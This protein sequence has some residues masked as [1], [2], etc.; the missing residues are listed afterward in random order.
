MNGLPAQKDLSP[1]LTTALHGEMV[2]KF[3]ATLD[4]LGNPNVVPIISLDTV[5]GGKL[6]F[7]EFLIHKTRANLECDHRVA[8]CVLTEDLSVW[9][10]R[11]DFQNFAEDGPY[12]DHL[13]SKDMFRY[14]AYVGVRRAAVFDLVAVTGSRKLSKL[15]VA[16]E[17]LPVLAMRTIAR[18]RG[19][20]GLPPR[21]A[22]KFARSQALKV[23][24]FQGQDGYPEIVPVFSLVPDMSNLMLFGT[25]LFRK[26]LRALKPGALVAAAVITMDP[27]AYQV[28]GVFEG[29]SRTPAGKLGRIR[30]DQ[31]YSA[32]PP[33]PGEPIAMPEKDLTS[34]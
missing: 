8:A 30:V 1:A 3:L 17:L 7:A 12:L 4:S 27:V 5:G 18:R 6:V 11:A 25:R 10:L 31:V 21:V 33:L 14:N 20:S 32:S 34:I 29:I 19:K 23:L 26:N 9:T 15:N 13:N 28:K 22:E 24:A 16:S 2:P